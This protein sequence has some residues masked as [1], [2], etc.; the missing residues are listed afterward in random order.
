MRIWY[1]GL[2][3]TWRMYFGRA[4]PQ[5][6]ATRPSPA[7]RIPQEIVEI[8]IAH[9]IY[10]RRSLLACSLTCYS[11]YIAAV[12][13]LHHTFITLTS[14][15]WGDLSLL[16][17]KPLLYKHRLGLLFL[18]KKLQIRGVNDIHPVG[19]SPSQLSLGLLPLFYA[20]N[21]VKEL[22]I[23]YL[24]IPGFKPWVRQYFSY[25]LP[26]VRSLTLREPRGSYR[27]II[28]FIGLFQHL[29]DLGLL[30]G[31]NRRFPEEQANDL[32]LNTPFAPPLR[33]RLT[34]TFISS[35]VFL[36]DMIDLLGGIQF[37][38][39]DLF[40]VHGMSLLL[41]ACAETLETLRFHP[42]DSHGESNII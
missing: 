3:E 23:D 13:H 35:I 34:M 37:R 7:T 40:H 20:L 32:A 16:W 22:E 9:L 5:V 25:L 27:Q 2:A 15:I 31:P 36:K 6:L 1:R 29:E 38:Q 41:K 10:D 8:I 30:F 24:D 33:G 21:N 19:F 4:S 26:T 18:V 42:N 12:P 17:P 14:F 28:W 11:W 39:L